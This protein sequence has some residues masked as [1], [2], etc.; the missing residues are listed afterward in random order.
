MTSHK[1]APYNTG[2]VKIGLAYEPRPPRAQ[3]AD[4]SRLQD[5]LLGSFDNSRERDI[6]RYVGLVLFV[7]AL[8]LVVSY[9]HR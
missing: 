4:E 8:A 2:K 1:S 3:S 6:K 9:A 5:A 7:I